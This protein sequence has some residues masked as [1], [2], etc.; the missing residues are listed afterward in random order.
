M[1]AAASE[2][3][4]FESLSTEQPLGDNVSG[5]STVLRDIVLTRHVI[6]L[7]HKAG[8]HAYTPSNEA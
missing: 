8:N 5:L 6:Q 7:H 1:H 3:V 2:A 4:F